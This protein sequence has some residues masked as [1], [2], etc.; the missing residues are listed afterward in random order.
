FET[1]RKT[2]LFPLTERIPWMLDSTVV[3]RAFPWLGTW[4][5]G[6]GPLV[7]PLRLRDGRALRIAP[8]IC[9][10]AL[11]AGHTLA[12]VRQGAEMIV[13]LSN[14]SWFAYGNVPRLILVISAFRSLETRRPQ[15][16]AANTGVSAVI[17]PTGTFLGTIGMDERG[18]L[19]RGVTPV[20]DTTT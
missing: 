5:P 16:R 14:G 6:N 15:V 4:K 3:R 17:T 1:Y 2:A 18:T 7:V 10:D 11:E 13:T 8:L 19:V 9:Y 20:R 12:A